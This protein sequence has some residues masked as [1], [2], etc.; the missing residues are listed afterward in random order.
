M[1]F[2][3]PRQVLVLGGGAREH[4]LAWRLARDPGVERVVVAPG[5]PGM[6]APALRDQ[7]AV[8]ADV[9]P[10][11]DPTDPLAVVALTQRL[12]PDLVVLGP[13]AP[14]VAG[15]ADALASAG[16]AALGPGAAGARLE[17]S[18]TF[19]RAVAEAAG[20]AMAPGRPFVTVA[21][22]LAFAATFDWQV[23]VKA[24]GLAAG[25]GVTVCADRAAT[26]QALREALEE[27]RFG[28]AGRSVVV[29]A[30]LAGVEASV[31]ALCDETAILALP[32]A[33]DHKR[34]RD[35]DEGP[36]T[37]GM[38]AY[39]PVPELPDLTVAA[40]V[41]AV[42]A[43]VLD[44]LRR[45]GVTFRGILYAGL[46]LTADGPRLL[47]FNVRLGDPEAQA[48]LPRVAVPLAPLLAAAATG[49]LAEAARALGL[50]ALAV[51]P[52]APAAAVAVVLAAAGYPEQP[53]RG[54]VLD[55]LADAR[56]TGSLVFAAG[57]GQGSGDGRLVTNG[58]R[59][60]T[61]V[62]QGP[63]LGRA[64]EAAYAAT[65]RI[66]FAGAQLR[67]DIVRTP[68]AVGR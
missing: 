6:N 59:V 1:N 31:M 33:R 5:N 35:G 55:G 43:P 62:G 22:A 34:L 32:A 7:G 23:V 25:K 63:D 50:P 19:T 12:A 58:G 38:G 60:V 41:A 53:R 4:A 54:D 66:R 11:L 48:C 10:D 20:V 37:G 68:A 8:V 44:E 2:A 45:R 29:E 56:A 64:A 21:P 40:V 30:R 28:P 26:E 3:T 49:R 57:V 65:D 27:G 52:Q 42:H 13:E 36:N 9:A 39:S 61:V 47:E 17:A 18:K 46:M 51:L 67:R 16:C 15:V 14:L 24:D